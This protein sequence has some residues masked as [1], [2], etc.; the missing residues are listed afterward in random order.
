MNGL[1]ELAALIRQQRDALLSSWQ[2]Q[3]KQLPSAR[4]LDAPT[5]ND[6]IPQLL[7]ELADALKSRSDQTIQ[8]ALA[9]GS[10]PVHGLVRFREGYDIEEVV[11]EY[12]IL[13]QCVHDLAKNRG[14]SLEG[15]SF[16]IMNDV[17][18]RA[19]GLA[20]Q[21]YATE[22]ALELQKR[23]E[24]YLAFVA[25]DLRTPLNAV[26]VVASGL[27]ETFR[28]RNAR[29]DTE[30]MLESLRRN[31]KQL[32][33]LVEKIIQENTNLCT[34]SSIKLERREFDLWP[35]AE[36]LIYDLRPLAKTS[37]TQLVNEVP[38]HL[39]VYADASL[40]KRVFQNLISNAVRHTPHGRVVLGARESTSDG[41]VECWVMDD[42]AGIS[43]DKLE[44]IFDELESD[45]AD[46]SG[47]GLGLAIIKRFVEAHGGR[48]NVESRQG[49]GSKFHFTLPMKDERE[50][51]TTQG[52]AAAHMML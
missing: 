48:V 5:L 7:D 30:W 32:Q 14:L 50:Q 4:N 34:E 27:E 41:T 21:T 23:R 1:N 3:V 47:L 40:L 49:L 13:R 46:G 18:D 44:R 15:E 16:H 33:G 43:R 12:N 22:R 28:D 11:A 29:E 8:E 19:I 35:L 24:E 36:A 6:H 26:A 31:V 45:S 10:P 25:H 42:G 17:L 51:S 39:V 20:V 9:K 52:F 37:G 38:H 2:Q